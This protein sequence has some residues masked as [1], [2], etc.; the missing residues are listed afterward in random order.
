[1]LRKKNR[2]A[3]RMVRTA[4]STELRKKA[5]GHF[6]SELFTEGLSADFHDRLAADEAH[7]DCG[8]TGSQTTIA[9]VRQGKVRG[10]IAPCSAQC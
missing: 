9:E 6:K 7:L 3:G 1:M 4:Q 8:V 2:K 5:N 10:R